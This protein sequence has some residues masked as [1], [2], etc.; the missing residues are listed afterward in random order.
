MTICRFWQQGN[1]R[2][3][4]KFP[5][6]LLRPLQPLRPHPAFT[7]TLL[8][9][10]PPLDFLP[11]IYLPLSPPTWI[12]HLLRP[13]VRLA[14]SSVFQPAPNLEHLHDLPPV[15]PARRQPRLLLRSNRPVPSPMLVA[16]TPAQRQ[17]GNGH[18]AFDGIVFLVATDPPL[19]SF[20]DLRS[21]PLSTCPLRWPTMARKTH[22]R[23]RTWFRLRQEMLRLKA[24]S[25][26][27]KTKCR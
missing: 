17:D 4:C 18:R 16:F 24:P 23:L 7:C 1:C 11:R 19:S 12:L 27:S 26:E 14:S 9:K 8:Q 6:L 2:Y 13:L 10:S 21:P 20:R 25:L 15:N 3:G 5:L 22:R